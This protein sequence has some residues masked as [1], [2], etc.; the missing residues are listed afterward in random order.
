MI[1]KDQVKGSVIQIQLAYEQIQ[2][3]KQ[4]QHLNLN[5]SGNFKHKFEAQAY[6]FTHLSSLSRQAF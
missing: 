5:L 2:K 4:K 1:S 6:M 3:L